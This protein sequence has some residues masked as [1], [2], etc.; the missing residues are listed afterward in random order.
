MR[1]I[2]FYLIFSSIIWCM[3]VQ[4]M[5]VPQSASLLANSSTGIAQHYSINPANVYRTEQFFSFSKNDWFID[6]KGQKISYLFKT[7]ND[8]K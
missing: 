4:T 3:G 1:K 5:Y 7:K 6:T 2:F 8:H